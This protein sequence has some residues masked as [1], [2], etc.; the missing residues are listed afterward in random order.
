[1]ALKRSLGGCVLPSNPYPLKKSFISLPCSRQVTVFHMAHTG[2]EI[3]WFLTEL[4]FQ[5]EL[6]VSLLA[7]WCTANVHTCL[8]FHSKMLKSEIYYKPCL[9]LKPPPPPQKKYTLFSVTT[10]L[11]H[12]REFST[13][14]NTSS[15]KHMSTKA[16]HPAWSFFAGSWPLHGEKVTIAPATACTFPFLPFWVL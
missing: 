13:W 1:M 12:I 10:S 16:A 3:M 6:L 15:T 4:F 11:G 7:S 9:R 14:V 5:K 2:T 8:R